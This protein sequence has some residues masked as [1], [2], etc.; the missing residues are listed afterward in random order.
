M[1]SEKEALPEKMITKSGHGVIG[2]KAASQPNDPDSLYPEGVDPG[3]VDDF[4]NARGQWS[5]YSE[6][7]RK[8]AAVL[9]KRY[10]ADGMSLSDALEKAF[11]EVGEPELI[12]EVTHGRQ[13]KLK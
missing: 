10:Q 6:K 9:S 5:P 12:D 13:K 3:I 4:H 8:A 2:G 11:Q 1:N 7:Q